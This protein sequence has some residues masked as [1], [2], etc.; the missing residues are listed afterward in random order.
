MERICGGNALSLSAITTA[1]TTETRKSMEPNKR[2]V[3]VR[4][5]V[6]MGA[7]AALLAGPALAQSGFP[8]AKIFEGTAISPANAAVYFSGASSLGTKIS[9]S[10]AQ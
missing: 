1:I 10:T 7:L 2:A 9:P 5:P 6:W 8:A 3:S 4:A